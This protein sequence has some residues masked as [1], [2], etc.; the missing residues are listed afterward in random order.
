MTHREL[1]REPATDFAIGWHLIFGTLERYCE[2]R[3]AD[4]LREEYASLSELYAHA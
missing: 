4:D 3:D 2:G 1:L